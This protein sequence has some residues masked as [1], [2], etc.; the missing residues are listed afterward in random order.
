MK[1]VER[2]DVADVF[3]APLTED[4]AGW[5]GGD[6]GPVAAALTVGLAFV[7]G[8]GISCVGVVGAATTFG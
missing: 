3:D 6:K 5:P 8:L 2:A 1:R 4:Q 7:S